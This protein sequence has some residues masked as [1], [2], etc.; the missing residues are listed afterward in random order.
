M[1]LHA[2][3]ATLFAGCGIVKGSSSEKEFDET[4]VKFTPMLNVLG[5]ENR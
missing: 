1:L 3:S 5:V 4:R 2:N